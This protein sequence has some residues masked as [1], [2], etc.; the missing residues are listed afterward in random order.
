M[1][2]FGE[3]E[4]RGTIAAA[5]GADPEF[6]MGTFRDVDAAVREACQALLESQLIPYKESIRGFIYDVSDGT[7]REVS[8]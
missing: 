1:G 7:V 2:R 4:L 3:E 8:S 6:A 5:T